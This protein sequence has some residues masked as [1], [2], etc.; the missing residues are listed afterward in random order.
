M[1]PRR[2]SSTRTISDREQERRHPGRQY[3]AGR[4]LWSADDDAF[5]RAI[6]PDQATPAVAKTLGRTL[7]S[8]YNRARILGLSKSSA[9]LDSPAACRLRRGDHVGRRFWFTKGHVPKNKGLRRPGY[10]VG[11][12]RETQFKKGGLPLNN[13]PIGSTRLVDGYVYRKVSAV[14]KVPYT[15][16]WK[17]EHHLIW[18]AKHGP[19]PVGSA[20]KFIDGNPQNVRLD[21]LQLISRSQLLARNS[22]HNLPPELKKTV[23]LL[24]ALTRQINKRTNAHAQRH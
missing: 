23:Q 20:L 16:N 24:G 21:N 2:R 15:V 13:M 12:M 3:R 4:W 1:A 17:P 10:S 19:I 7:A 18:I 9:Y 11:R 6:Y 22:I 8:T 14:P 5:L